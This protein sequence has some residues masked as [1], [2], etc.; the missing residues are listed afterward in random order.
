MTKPQL[1]K[2]ADEIEDF[3]AGKIDINTFDEY[4]EKVVQV[5]SNRHIHPELYLELEK[6]NFIVES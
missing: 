3:V 2:L 5:L 1:I 6:P 4:F